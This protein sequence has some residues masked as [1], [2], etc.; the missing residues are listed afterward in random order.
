MNK[1]FF[2]NLYLISFSLL[3]IIWFVFLIKMLNSTITFDYVRVGFV[4][5]WGAVA[6]VLSFIP[7]LYI[8][9]FSYKYIKKWRT[10]HNLIYIL[11]CFLIII[12]SFVWSSNY[13]DRSVEKNKKT[14]K[15]ASVLKTQELVNG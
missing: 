9:L 2:L 4:V 3:A 5:A 14:H 6:F 13:I 11:T 8:L 7:V 10:V 1:N 15:I 12:I